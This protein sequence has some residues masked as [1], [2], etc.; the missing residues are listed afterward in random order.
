[1]A[2]TYSIDRSARTAFL[3]YQRNPRFDEW[4]AV[5]KALL[6]DPSYEPGFHIFLDRSQVEEAPD[7]EYVRK[8]V[9][10]IKHNESRFS[11]SRW[12][13]VVRNQA[14]Y[15]ME[16]MAELLTDSTIVEMSVFTD[17]SEAENWLQ[18]KE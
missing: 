12:V 6:N 17:K 3:H 10:F 5:M 18:A 14:N 1:M 9:S 7:T 2:L 4:E 15:G 16:R 8:V 13:A 11:Q